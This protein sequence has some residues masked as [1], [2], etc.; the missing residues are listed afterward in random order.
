[1]VVSFNW[2]KDYLKFD[3]TPAEVEKILTSTGLE[4]EHVETTE[5]IPGGLA[6]VIVAEVV[7]CV[8]HP[9]SD[10]LHITKLNTGA[11]ELLQVVC[12]APN[13]AAG[14]KVLLATVG[15]ELPTEDG[16]K[17]KI[18]RSKIRGV[19]SLG[20]ICAEDELGIGNDHSGIM[21]LEPSAAP[22][23][24]AKD[25]LKLKTDTVFEIGLTP[26]R[27]DGASHIGVARDLFAYCRTN[28]IA[29]EWTLPQVEPLQDAPGASIPVKVK[30]PD[31]A[32]RYIGVTI[33][34]V[35]VGPSPEWLKERLQSIGQRPINNIVDITNFVLNET[36]HP[37]HAFD[38]AKIKGR[39]VVVRRSEEGRKFTTLDGIE[40]T[41]SGNDLVI[42]NIDEPMCIA[43]VFGGQDSGVTESTTEIFLE[44][45]YFNPVTVRKTSKRHGIKTDASFR[46]ERGIDPLATMDAAAR[47]ARL[48]EQIAGGRITGKIQECCEA[49]F[50]KAQVEL[51]YARMESLIGKSLGADT[52]KSILKNLEFEILEESESG[53]K[54]AVPSY[55][56]DVLRECDVVEEVLRI[57][58]YNNIELP[59]NMK[60]SVNPSLHPDPENVRK[61]V[62]DFFAGRGFV[63]I[64]NNSL[65]KSDYYSR[66]KTFPVDNCVNVVNPLSSDLNCMRQTLILNA[67]EVVSRNINHQNPDLK[68]FEVGNCYSF[69]PKENSENPKAEL[70]SYKE[71][72]R[73]CLTITGQGGKAWRNE[74]GSGHYF[75]LKGYLELLLHRFGANLYDLEAVP[76]PQDIFAE[77]MEYKLQGKRLA[78]AG[79]VAKG[80][81][82]SFDIKQ[83][84][85]VAEI[86][87]PVF[88]E[89]VK[90]DKVK[91]SELPKYPEV[92]RDLAIL[93]DEEVS[94]ADIR[95]AAFQAEKGLLKQVS[96]F[97]VYRGDK[98]A[99]GKKQYAISFVLQDL[100]KTLTDNAVEQAV[101]RLLKAFEKKFGAVLR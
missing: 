52:I 87:W 36:G 54:V 91:Y 26:N 41:L 10:H 4:V 19:E 29:C 56:V 98:I 96:L 64:M 16:G 69:V 81:L 82:K 18:K 92:K 62:S 15:T 88:F 59:A 24:P 43:G 79:T 5:Q 2:L 99:S 100:E 84:V 74:L 14:Q 53:C 30:D 93:L 97:D 27:V 1:M 71:E 31:L 17:F 20:M 25:Y 23:T 60:V 58:G 50:E 28:G 13:V 95:K 90:R 57:Y 68:L 38:A 6:G 55:R 33:S 83:S 89:L 40:R 66:L 35:K 73:L 7:E 3:L 65:T 80:L 32:P 46:Y 51:N 78:M 72:M 49:P 77:G 94:F 22:G 67:L 11:E 9:D 86:N 44:A 34:D 8:E 37:L 12:G 70:K 76:A 63:E 101:G 42:C 21:V 39:K 61:T 75:A 85:Y 45:A 48:V 47:A